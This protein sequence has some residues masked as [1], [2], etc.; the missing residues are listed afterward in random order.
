MTH[1]PAF[2]QI[3]SEPH[4]LR[5]NFKTAS[6]SNVASINIEIRLLRQTKTAKMTSQI[7]L[8]YDSNFTSSFGASTQKEKQY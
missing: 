3:A 2:R 7:K 6:Q 8:G 4:R 5:G 1:L